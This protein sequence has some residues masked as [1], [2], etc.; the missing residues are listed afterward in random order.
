MFKLFKRKKPE[1][2]YDY[3]AAIARLSSACMKSKAFSLVLPSVYYDIAKG[4]YVVHFTCA[5]REYE[6]G[7]KKKYFLS[8]RRDE[9]L[10]GENLEDLLEF[11]VTYANYDDAFIRS[12][13]DS[14]P[15]G[16]TMQIKN[17]NRSPGRHN[18]T[19]PKFNI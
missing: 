1:P 8:I 13:Q 11:A 15:D 4:E 17:I 19:L 18:P 7:V 14:L 10:R 5:Q 6:M 16:I 3:G 9:K 12:P 2:H